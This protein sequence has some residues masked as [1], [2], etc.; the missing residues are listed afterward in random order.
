MLYKLSSSLSCSVLFLRL[1]CWAW[2][3]TGGSVV[4]ASC[5]K[6]QKIFLKDLDAFCEICTS[7][8][9]PLNGTPYIY[10]LII[11]WSNIPLCSRALSSS[12]A[13]CSSTVG[14]LRASISLLH[15]GAGLVCC[16]QDR[17]ISLK[18]SSGLRFLRTSRSLLCRF[19]L[20]P[21]LYHLARA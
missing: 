6:L 18:A 2:P 13:G 12:C 9:F 19:S 1:T 5:I 10:K 20:R 17:N 11:M 15:V 14:L 3:L 21:M 4:R 7:E 16:N 8:N